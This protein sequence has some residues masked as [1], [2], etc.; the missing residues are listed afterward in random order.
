MLGWNDSTYLYA[1][2]CLMT[3]TLHEIYVVDGGFMGLS[4]LPFPCR[5]RTPRRI[6]H[7]GYQFPQRIF[8]GIATILLAWSVLSNISNPAYAVIL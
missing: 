7:P 8:C 6:L 2:I 1:E 4:L 3:D 5:I